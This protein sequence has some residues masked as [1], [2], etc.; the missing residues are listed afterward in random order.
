MLYIAIT[1]T[2]DVGVFSF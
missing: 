2:N 1:D